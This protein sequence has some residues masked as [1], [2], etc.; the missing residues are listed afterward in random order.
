MIQRRRSE[1]GQVVILGILILLVLIFLTAALIDAYS[2]YEARDWG[3][4][5]AQQ[6]A[7]AGVSVS[8]D[9]A[10]VTQP[11][12]AGCTGPVAI[13]LNEAEARNKAD[14]VVQLE[15]S[16]RGLI[17]YTRDI[18]VLP[19]YDGGTI[20]NFPPSPVRLGNSLGQ[21]SANEPSVGVYL[22]FP[23][24]T[25]LLSFAGRPT[26]DVHVFASASV[27]QPAGACPP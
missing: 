23:V 16:S 14:Q 4:Q 2:I 21:W 18:R 24:S 25:F 11:P 15:I 9:W 13:T 22:S 27:A 17:S 5:V 6:A 20:S 8:R 1:S 3:Y 12:G 10:G 26:V 7:L 19:D